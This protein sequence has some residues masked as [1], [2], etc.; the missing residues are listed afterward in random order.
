MDIAALLAVL[1]GLFAA[2]A[3]TEPLADRLR[4]PSTVVLAAMGI[5]VGAG[6]AWFWATPLTDALNPVA[7]AILRLPINSGI[8]LY[9]F[10]PILI[11]QVSLTL[12]LRRM[13]DD[14]VPILTLAVV[15]V[16][17]AT[18]V[19]ALALW[20]ISGL[21]LI[22]CLL[23][24]AIVSTTDPSA[25]VT[26]FRSIPA[27]QRLGR[28]V[29]GE[30]LLNDAAAIALF[31]VF[32][33]DVIRRA[34]EP[35]ILGALS[36]FPFVILAGAAVGWVLGRVAVSVMGRMGDYPLGQVTLSLAVPFAT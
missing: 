27:P 28:I 13:L 20:P 22:A 10:L 6:A 2:I 9:V 23:I 24:A 26:I 17:V 21:P 8:F 14:W 36:R 29:E 12:N 35:D 7:L 18:G 32:L 3:L 31:G 16:I 4:L 11:F 1:A 30:S 19:I 5:A 34:D 15:A 33:T 25:V